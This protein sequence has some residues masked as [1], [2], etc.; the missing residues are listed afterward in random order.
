M[1][2]KLEAT[3]GTEQRVLAYLEANASE[4]LVDRINK[5]EKTIAG[6]LNYAKGEALKMAQD[7]SCVCV[8]D[9][10]VFGWIIHYFEEDEIKEQKQRKIAPMAPGRKI[11][12]KAKKTAPVVAPAD[13]QLDMFSALFGGK[14]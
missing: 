6:A 4:T 5:G 3:N 7:Q 14:Q 12:P 11:E 1:R 8:D 10:T 13:A 2:T 9:E